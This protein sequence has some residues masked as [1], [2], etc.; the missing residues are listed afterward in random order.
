[1][2]RDSTV[3]VIDDDPS[4][5]EATTDLLKSMGM[6][7]VAC[8]SAQEYIACERPQTPSCLVLDV[9]LPDVNGLDLQCEL[10]GGAHPPIVFISGHGDIPMTVRAMRAGA[11]DFLSKPF[12][13]D[14]LVTAV[15]A[16]LAKHRQTLAQRTEVADLLRRHA[17]LTPR[18]REVF[19]LAVSGLLNKQAAAQLGISEVT[20]QI[21]RRQVMRKMA[22]G[23]FAELVRMSVQLNAFGCQDVAPVRRGNPQADHSRG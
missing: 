9:R 1:M 22:A 15:A 20:L 18:E 2:N 21:H 14:Q 17:L 8:R 23:S 7:V 19:A 10:A 11:I 12:S 5:L 16:A 4:V 13:D 6:G 3:F